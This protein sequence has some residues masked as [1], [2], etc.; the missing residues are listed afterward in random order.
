MTR[1]SRTIILLASGCLATLL[2][3]PV[4]NTAQAQPAKQTSNELNR[5]TVERRAVEAAIWGMPIVNFDAMRQAFFRDAKANYNDIVFWSKPGSWKNQCLT[6][7]T[8]VR[9]VFSFINTH[10]SGPVVIDLPPTGDATLVGTII[11]AWQVPV[12]DVGI[13]GVDKGK[14]G[15]YLLLP[16]DFKG[17][18]PADYFVL[19]MKTYNAFVGHIQHIIHR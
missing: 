1:L 9:Y 18:V 5:R 4:R 8:T 15:K 13:A 19:P 10:Q 17:D 14:G 11:D 7:N 2:T 6:P 12:A 3:G 16:P